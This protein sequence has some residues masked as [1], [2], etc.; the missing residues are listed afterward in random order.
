MN[1]YLKLLM[2]QFNQA[3]GVKTPD[4]HSNTYISDFIEWIES[5]Q[6][7][8]KEYIR[9]LEDMNQEKIKSPTTIEVGKGKYDSIVL[10][11]DTKIITPYSEDLE[12]IK[13]TRVITSDFMVVG[14]MPVSYR[15]TPDGKL[16]ETHHIPEKERLTFMTQNPYT[17]N[18]IKNWDQLYTSGRC[19]I[20]IGIYG[21]VHDKDIDIKVKELKKI[22]EKLEESYI[23]ESIVEAD[24]YCY[25]IASAKT[26]VKTFTKTRF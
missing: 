2:K 9:L 3:T 16:K 18:N 6:K 14:G 23:Q 12:N 20:V 10:P 22:K 15:T 4:I 25:A 21:D 24:T 19:D 11:F 5:R 8:S 1:K 26:K 13:E 17:P 7:S